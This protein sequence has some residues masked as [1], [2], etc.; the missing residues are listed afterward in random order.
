MNHKAHTQTSRPLGRVRRRA[1]AG[2]KPERPQGFE[3]ETLAQGKY[4]LL[5]KFELSIMREA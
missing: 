5:T 4:A 2:N 3:G 1:K